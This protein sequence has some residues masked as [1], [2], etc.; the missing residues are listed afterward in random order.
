M[1]AQITDLEN[2]DSYFASSRADCRDITDASAFDEFVRSGGE[3]IL[4][5]GV[6]VSLVRPLDTSRPGSVMNGI[7]KTGKKGRQL[8]L[9]VESKMIEKIDE[10]GSC[11]AHVFVAPNDREAILYASFNLS[12]EAFGFAADLAGRGALHIT[13]V[14][15]KR[16]L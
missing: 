10:L 12:D 16:D 8:S 13:V 1:I 4:M 3:T 11:R 7:L 14:F 5:G 6:C 9:Q 15:E 2:C